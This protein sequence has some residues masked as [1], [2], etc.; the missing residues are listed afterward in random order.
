MD[1]HT[2]MAV[3]VPFRSAQKVKKQLTIVS[4]VIATDL[5]EGTGAN[6]RSTTLFRCGAVVGITGAPSGE[7][8]TD[9][10]TTKRIIFNGGVMGTAAIAGTTPVTYRPRCSWNHQYQRV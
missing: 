10:C 7:L 5:D 9:A 4:D 8:V 6:V 3:N 2:I 1:V